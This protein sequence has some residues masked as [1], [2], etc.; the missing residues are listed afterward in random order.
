MVD[1]I[2][3]FGVT[4]YGVETFATFY[5]F[6]EKFQDEGISGVND[7]IFTTPKYTDTK[8]S[9]LVQGD[10]E[11]NPDF[12]QEVE[13]YFYVY[14]ALFET[15]AIASMAFYDPIYLL[16]WWPRTAAAYW[17]FAYSFFQVKA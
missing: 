7:M 3:K 8:F 16:Q 11:F 4:I 6:F 5:P 10:L 17:D 12:A 13:F 9:M 15:S 14:G 1:G 2:I